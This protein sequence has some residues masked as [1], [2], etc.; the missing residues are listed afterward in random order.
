MPI[1]QWWEVVIMFWQR[2]DNRVRNHVVL[3]TPV[4]MKVTGSWFPGWQ[5]AQEKK[6]KS[7]KSPRPPSIWRSMTSWIHDV[8]DKRVEISKKSSFWNTKTIVSL[9]PLATSWRSSH[10]LAIFDLNIAFSDATFLLESAPETR[11][12]G[13]KFLPIS[14]SHSYWVQVLSKLTKVNISIDPKWKLRPCDDFS[15]SQRF[16]FLIAITLYETNGFI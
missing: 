1:T 13:R 12:C 4:K 9:L 7:H 5:K 16:G 11:R 3:L 15:S 2:K 6:K 8:A 14:Y 10:R